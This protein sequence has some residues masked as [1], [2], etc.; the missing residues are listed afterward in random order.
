M[1]SPSVFPMSPYSL[2]VSWEKPQDNLARGE[3]MGY[4]IN[5]VTEQKILPALSQ[6]LLSV[7]FYGFIASIT[8]LSNF[9]I[10]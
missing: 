1:L 8:C 5:L 10:H 6:V 7:S 4:S 2:N 9:F 3:V